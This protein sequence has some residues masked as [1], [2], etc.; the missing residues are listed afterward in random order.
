MIFT[1][2]IADAARD[3]A[4]A[5]LLI[6]NLTIITSLSSNQFLLWHYLYLLFC[7][8]SLPRHR[9]TLG[10]N[11]AAASAIPFF[12]LP[13]L[14]SMI[15]RKQGFLRIPGLTPSDKDLQRSACPDAAAVMADRLS[16]VVC[17]FAF[18]LLASC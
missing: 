17:L 11:I 9:P 4:L 7:S 1:K 6:M 2:A 5:N 10:W 3:F 15:D 12:A 13:S 14:H 16:L 8:A 18:A